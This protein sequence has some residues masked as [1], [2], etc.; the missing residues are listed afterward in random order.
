MALTNFS[1]YASSANRGEIRKNNFTFLHLLGALLVIFGHM[2]Y[3]V[4][5]LPFTICG[6]Y[7]Q[8]F[9]CKIIFI[10]SGYLV[11]KSYLREPYFLPY[12]KK[13]V[14]KIFP[15]L[16]V[17]VLLT[18]FVLGPIFTNLT[19]ITYFTNP[20]TWAYLSNIF[21]YPRFDLPVVFINNPY[22]Y[23]INGSLWTIPIEILCYLLVP[24][25]YLINKK[26][27]YINIVVLLLMTSV[28][29]LT[30]YVFKEPIVI[31]GTN[32]LD[33]CVLGA[34]F[35]FG[36]IFA[37]IDDKKIY[38]IHNASLIFFLLIAVPLNKDIKNVLLIPV[39]TY[40][41]LSF[42]NI[43]NPIFKNVLKKHNIC[44]GLYLYGFPIQQI[45]VV[46]LKQYD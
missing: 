11:T 30:P 34:Y 7:V 40:L 5:E 24:L 35:V 21:L 44:Y 2:Y 15:S 42:G 8:V 27:P 18:I 41:V 1:S 3:F 45:I 13:R 16:T 12:L 43:P 36:N 37:L 39:L 28:V 6:N 31:Y 46:L 38:N 22:P 26:R 29:A 9:G 25:F 14:F 10:L 33:I 19:L 17:I 32:L 4:G 23:A 20:Y